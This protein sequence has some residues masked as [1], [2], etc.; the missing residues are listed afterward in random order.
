MIFQ[1]LL[2]NL[3]VRASLEGGKKVQS[4]MH[5]VQI[6]AH[7]SF[8]KACARY[9]NFGV[10]INYWSR[11]TL[12]LPGLRGGGLKKRPLSETAPAKKKK[13][14]DAGDNKGVQ[15]AAGG[16]LKRDIS[17]AVSQNQ[18]M[19]VSPIATC[20]L[21][22]YAIRTGNACRVPGRIVVPSS[23]QVYGTQGDLPKDTKL[24][25][26]KDEG[27]HSC[28]CVCPAVHIHLRKH[29]CSGMV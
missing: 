1:A 12:C 2:G 26:V 22:M 20:A 10:K 15:V 11:T 25:L 17:K 6:P 28:T 7:P 27:I 16:L 13:H 19:H 14:K 5:T 24:Q 21:H 8:S 4:N 9:E 3:S 29:E 18:S 23:F